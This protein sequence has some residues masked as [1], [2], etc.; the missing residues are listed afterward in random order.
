MKNKIPLFLLLAGASDAL[1]GLLL[2][3]A[4]AFTLDLMLVKSIPRE[5][6]YCQFIGAFVFSIGTSYLRPFLHPAGPER[7]SAIRHVLA[8]TAWVRVCIATF[9]ALAIATGRLHA[10]WISVPLFDATLAVIQLLILRH[11]RSANA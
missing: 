11:L 3:L 2:V 5:L 9:S 6:V 7:A 8:A 10:S 4:P 1:T